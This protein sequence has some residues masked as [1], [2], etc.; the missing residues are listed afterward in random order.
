[1]T[2][3]PTEISE[4]FE[5]HGVFAEGRT[6]TLHHATERSSGRKGLL[7]LLRAETLGA[8]S[9]RQRIKR[10]LAKQVTLQ[11]AT[12]ALPWASGEV[13]KTLWLFREHVAGRTLAQRIAQDGP[14][15][16]S[17]ALAVVAQLAEGLDELH[18]AGLL[19]RDLQPAHVVLK[20]DGSVV[21]FGAGIA[22]PI[23]HEEVFELYGTP[24]YVSPEQTAGK[25]VSFRSDLYALGCFFHALVHGKPPFTGSV[26]DVLK[27]HAEATPPSFEGLAPEAA[28]LLEQ[29]LA[30]DPKQRP[31]S[32]Q[33]VRRG[34]DPFLPDLLKS[35]E[36]PMPARKATILGM[37]A[38]S[39]PRPPSLEPPRPPSM[40]PPRPPSMEP[41]KAAKR[42]PDATQQVALDDILEEGAAAAAAKVSAPP[43]PPPGVRMSSAPPPPPAAA[44]K[45]AET[46]QQLDALDLEEEIAEAAPDADTSGGF[47]VLSEPSEEEAPRAN[48]A[49]APAAI[50]AAPAVEAVEAA[51]EAPAAAATTDLDYDD[52]AE[53][54]ARDAPSMLAPMAPSVDDHVQQAAEPAPE[55][56]PAPQARRD[57]TPVLPEE[58]VSHTP[59]MTAV[60]EPPPNRNGLYALAGGALVFLSV[61]LFIGYQA[62]GAKPENV[63]S[64]MPAPTLVGDAPSASPP[65]ASATA[66]EPAVEAPVVAV[67]EPVAAVEEPV[68]EEAIA[69]EAIAEEAI[70]EEAVVEETPAE[71][72]V[73][74]EEAV[75]D[76]AAEE[77]EVEEAAPGRRRAARRGTRRARARST[78]GSPFDQAREAARQAFQSRNFPAA[79]AAY[80]RATAI[81]PRHAGSWAGLGAARMQTRNF[82][83]AVQAYQRAVQLS[84]TNSGYFTMLGHALRMA[85]NGAGAQQAYQRAL[86][87]DPSNRAAQQGLGR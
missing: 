64:A 4:R 6:G 18:R 51:P 3:I 9:D 16:S 2:D 48:V 44:R 28:T 40:E 72:A 19:F 17:E 23:D 13:G 29:L 60:T 41:P 36:M 65:V 38:V 49:D 85:G 82:G 27:A 74:A 22:A 43:P 55:P 35:G 70:A 30:K 80:V 83:G 25:L 26:A 71:E 39:P 75:E 15:T 77:D 86:A 62:F 52:L 57:S 42:N 37:P 7:K 59:T 84:P 12:L 32:A 31:F 53:T 87:I 66:P 81:N 47:E 8:A 20:D 33:Q 79:E 61:L 69:E 45:T 78:G 50:V 10:E 76:E 73:V 68:A 54:I 58:R 24:E 56:Q 1:M 21:A 46:T 63:S 5:L 34:L 67:A 14:I 11:H